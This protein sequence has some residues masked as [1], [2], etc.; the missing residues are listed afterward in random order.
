MVFFLSTVLTIECH[1]LTNLPTLTIL[2]QINK[3]R[4]SVPTSIYLSASLGTQSE[5]YVA[6]R[7]PQHPL[8]I[9][10]T[11]P[12]AEKSEYKNSSGQENLAPAHNSINILSTASK[13]KSQT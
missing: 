4:R 11:S 8:I 10:Q 5:N 7:K 2:T 6:H 12:T 13:S 1:A 3:T 9:L